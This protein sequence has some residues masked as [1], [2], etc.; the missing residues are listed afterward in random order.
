[1][2]SEAA[3]TTVWKLRPGADKRIR[4]GHPWVFSNELAASPKGHAAGAAVELQD[5]RGQFVARGYGN[6]HSLIAFRALSFLNHETEPLSYEALQAKILRAWK[7]RKDLGFK[8]S[9]RL[10]FGESDY[11]PGLVLD[12]YLIEQGGKAFQVFAAQLV[13]AGMDVALHDPAL[14]FQELVEKAAREQLSSLD[15]SE[16]AVV[17]RNDVSVRKLEGLNVEAPRTVKE[18]AGVN[19]AAVDILLNS[20]SDEGLLPMSCDLFEGQKTGFFLDQTHNIHLAVELFKN[21]ALAK[22]PRKVRVLDLCCYVGHWSAQVARLMKSLEIEIEVHLVD[23]SKTALEFARKNAERQ[24]AQVT[25]HEMDVLEGL[26]GLPPQHFDIVIA[27]PPAF[28]KA[29]KDIPT[30]K[31]AYLKMNTQAFRVAKPG[32][33]VVSCSC[34]GLLVEEEFRDALRKAA[35]RNFSE[36]RSVLRGGHAADHPTLMQFPEGFYLKMYMHQV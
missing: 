33:F 19:V 30:G 2:K 5:A 28:I 18:I 4:S 32:G 27:D 31:H 1:M 21:W 34:S 6:P 23:V 13:T 20:A 36:I 17:L 3:K 12:Y 8:G 15:W 35:L 16:T 9:C 24:G 26:S 22:K 11:L 14:F 10:C 25:V 7:I 29:K